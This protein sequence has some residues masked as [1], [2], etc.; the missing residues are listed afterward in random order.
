MDDRSSFHL[1]ATFFCRWWIDQDVIRAQDHRKFPNHLEKK[2]WK[3]LTLNNQIF[4][5]LFV[6]RSQDHKI[7][8]NCKYFALWE[9]FKNNFE[10]S[11]LSR[12]SCSQEQ[13]T[14]SWEIVEVWATQRNFMGDLNWKGLEKVLKCQFN[15]VY[16]PVKAWTF[17][18]LGANTCLHK[19]MQGLFEWRSLFERNR[20]VS[21]TE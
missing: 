2:C 9:S 16:C 19:R 14:K 7:T 12:P 17:S 4:P 3:V 1:R 11:N 5:D 10:Q 15:T 20:W 21:Q 13:R 8:A 18:V 6:I